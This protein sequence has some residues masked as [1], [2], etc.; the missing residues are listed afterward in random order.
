M[1]FFLLVLFIG[2]LS[3]DCRIKNRATKTKIGKWNFLS[4]ISRN[5]RNLLNNKI[6][7]KKYYYFGR[8]GA[9][10]LFGSRGSSA[11]TLTLS[12]VE[13]VPAVSSVQENCTILAMTNIDTK[14]IFFI[15]LDLKIRHSLGCPIVKSDP[16][17]SWKPLNM[18][19][20]FI[21][22]GKWSA[23][24]QNNRIYTSRIKRS[25]CLATLF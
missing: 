20:S 7:R 22:F 18:E 14:I 17:Q 3:Q 21:F 23:L 13:F 9:V 25:S 12:L 8:G 19:G 16:F 5:Y 6:S 4:I 15:F 24:K 10:G 2:F 11:T 1:L